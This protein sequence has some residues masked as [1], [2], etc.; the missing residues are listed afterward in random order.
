M[1]TL[2]TT[3]DGKSYGDK[4]TNEALKDMEGRSWKWVTHSYDASIERLKSKV[5]EFQA[6][7]GY[8]V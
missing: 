4:G 8:R 2:D 3:Q 5:T 1:G 6:S 7:L